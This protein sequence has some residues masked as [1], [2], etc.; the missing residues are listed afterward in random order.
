MLSFLLKNQFQIVSYCFI[1]NCFPSFLQVK[2]SLQTKRM[3]II[4]I[5]CLC[6]TNLFSLLKTTNIYQCCL[7]KAFVQVEVVGTGV[8]NLF[9]SFA[10]NQKI[11]RFQIA[12]KLLWFSTAKF[13]S[14]MYIRIS[15]HF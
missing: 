9:C 12:Q 6:K 7:W 15:K 3:V 5:H 8:F 2:D 4:F 13:W 11:T 1:S 14:L 10:S